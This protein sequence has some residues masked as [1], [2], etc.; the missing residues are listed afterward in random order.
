MQQRRASGG[1][2]CGACAFATTEAAALLLAHDVH[3]ATSLVNTY[4]RSFVFVAKSQMTSFG[5]PLTMLLLLL[6]KKLIWTRRGGG[7]RVVAVAVG[8][9]PQTLCAPGWGNYDHAT[10]HLCQATHPPRV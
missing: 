9:P 6:A 3:D 1:G 5:G 8:V 2:H 7:A 10:R 4:S